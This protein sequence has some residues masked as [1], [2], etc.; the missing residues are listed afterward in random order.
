LQLSRNFEVI[1]HGMRF[2]IADAEDA[3]LGSL[4]MDFLEREALHRAA[5]LAMEYELRTMLNAGKVSGNALQAALDV[6]ER[7]RAQPGG[8]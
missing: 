8:R 5:D 4:E 2:R 3:V 7:E 6:N 1:D